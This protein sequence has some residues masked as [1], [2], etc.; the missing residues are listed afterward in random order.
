MGP[1]PSLKSQRDPVRWLKDA[2][3]VKAAPESEIIEVK[4][5]ANDGDYGDKMLILNRIVNSVQ[6]ELAL[7]AARQKKRVRDEAGVKLVKCREQLQRRSIALESL[8]INATSADANAVRASLQR[9][10]ED[11]TAE[12][13]ELSLR[14]E[15]MR[16]AWV[17]RPRDDARVGGFRIVQPVLAES[18]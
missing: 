12:G 16:L 14:I 6:H 2:L 10:I 15:E 3:I 8:S 7:E 9:E 5:L 17:D 11:L 4:F 1:L 13:K 18:R